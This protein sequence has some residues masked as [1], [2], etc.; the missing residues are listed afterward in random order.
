MIPNP[1]YAGPKKLGTR[2]E[3]EMPIASLRL[4]LRG[5]DNGLRSGFKPMM[6]Y[7]QINESVV[8]HHEWQH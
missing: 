2:V 7:V 1:C 4:C 3:P 6:A 8:V 5:D